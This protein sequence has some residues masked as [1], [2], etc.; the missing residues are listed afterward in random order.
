MPGAGPERQRSR[1]KEE[2]RQEGI[3]K[4]TRRLRSRDAMRRADGKTWR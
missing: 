1:E 3:G 2:E 4:E